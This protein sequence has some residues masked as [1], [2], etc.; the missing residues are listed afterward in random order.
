LC[1]VIIRRRVAGKAEPCRVDD[2]QLARHGVITHS[3]EVTG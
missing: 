3:Y 1:A 2:R